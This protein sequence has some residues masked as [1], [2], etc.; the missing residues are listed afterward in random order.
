MILD[1]PQHAMRCKHILK[2]C[3]I[4]TLSWTT[5]SCNPTGPRTP[6]DSDSDEHELV[7]MAELTP[8]VATAAL[9][10]RMDS[11]EAGMLKYLDRKELAAATLR[12][13][14]GG[15]RVAWGPFCLFLKEQRYSVTIPDPGRTDGHCND[16]EGE[17]EKATDGRWIPTR[18]HGL[19]IGI[20]KSDR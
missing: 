6:A 9:L 8:E 16:F 20:K 17:F 4:V 19:S 11:A 5:I 13:E 12:L 18:P 3:M 15:R 10:Q 14:D 2:A 1:P 7:M